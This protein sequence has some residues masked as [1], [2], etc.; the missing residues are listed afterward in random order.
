M[1]DKLIGYIKEKTLNALNIYGSILKIS[2]ETLKVSAGHSANN[3]FAFRAYL[4]IM[5]NVQRDE[6]AVIVNIRHYPDRISIQSD[7]CMDNGTV[8]SVGPFAEI[9]KT[10]EYSDQYKKADEWINSLK[11]FLDEHKINILNM[12]VNL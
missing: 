1:A 2:N 8:I 12:V 4:S 7:I 6:I 11:F 10:K 5:K 9:V 3:T